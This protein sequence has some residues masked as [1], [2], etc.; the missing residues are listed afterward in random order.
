MKLV[1]GEKYL[2]KTSELDLLKQ[3]CK[4]TLKEKEIED[5]D[6]N[7]L[8]AAFGERFAKAWEAV[9]DKRV[10]KYIFRPSNRVVWI[11]VG[12]G[13]DYLI[14]PAADFCTCDD[15]YFRVMDKQV[16]LCY[17]LIAQKLAD[18]LESYVLYEEEDELYKVLMREWKKAIA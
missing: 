2:A 5:A 16:H 6:L 11:V 12:K 17:H 9:K 18:T 14:M 13:R 15:F 7:K 3:I 1:Y 8:S 4:K 10:K